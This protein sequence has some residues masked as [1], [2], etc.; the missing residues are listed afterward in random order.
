MTLQEEMRQ[1][2]KDIFAADGLAGIISGGDE[3]IDSAITQL[4]DAYPA[5]KANRKG[6]D[7]PF[8]ELVH[9]FSAMVTGSIIQTGLRQT[10]GAIAD[11]YMHG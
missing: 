9:D 7:Y 2:A 1:Q 5:A 4:I 11:R 10:R 6:K 8:T 3:A